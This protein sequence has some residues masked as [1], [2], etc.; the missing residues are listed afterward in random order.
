M[1]RRLECALSIDRKH[2]AALNLT[3]KAL[4]SIITGCQSATIE[5]D[6][7]PMVCFFKP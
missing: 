5:Y 3:H 2:P 6:G 7:C 1:L 4:A